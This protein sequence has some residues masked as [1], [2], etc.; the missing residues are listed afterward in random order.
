MPINEQLELIPTDVRGLYF[1]ATTMAYVVLV[2]NKDTFIEVIGE[3]RE[4]IAIKIAKMLNP[5]TPSQI[6]KGWY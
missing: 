4:E 1:D 6:K 5:E 2:H 3:D